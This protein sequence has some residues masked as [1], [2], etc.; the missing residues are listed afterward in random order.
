MSNWPKTAPLLLRYFT[1]YMSKGCLRDLARI[2][3]C[4]QVVL[5]MPSDRQTCP[6]LG[7]PHRLLTNALLDNCMSNTHPH[8]PP[9]PRHRPLISFNK[10]ASFT[11]PKLYTVVAI[12]YNFGLVEKQQ[13][14]SF[15]SVTNQ[16]RPLFGDFRRRRS[17]SR[18]HSRSRRRH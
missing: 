14:M 10:E 13:H 9:P 5:N 4:L 6:A 8:A 3:G 7:S 11:R 17:S 18:S 2:C 1:S 16:H 12:G 15:V